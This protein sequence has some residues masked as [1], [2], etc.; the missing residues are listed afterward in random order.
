MTPPRKW[1]QEYTVLS[2]PGLPGSVTPCWSYPADGRGARR[3]K[4][5]RP[6]PPHALV[7]FPGSSTTI[8]PLNPQ[9]GPG[10]ALKSFVDL[11]TPRRL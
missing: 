3:L 10:G 4:T 5:R 2:P 9:P 7:P 11:S 8:Q 1:R 6:F